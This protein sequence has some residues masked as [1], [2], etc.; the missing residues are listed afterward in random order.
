MTARSRFSMDD[1]ALSSSK[2]LFLGGSTAL[3]RM[4]G[5]RRRRRG[6]VDLS[7]SS[8]PPGS[9]FHSSFRMS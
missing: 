4:K 5:P 7:P 3:P 8:S 2:S 1:A 6:P 9:L